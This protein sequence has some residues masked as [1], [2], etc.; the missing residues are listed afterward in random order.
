MLRSCS[1][2]KGRGEERTQGWAVVLMSR[3]IQQDHVVRVCGGRKEGRGGADLSLNV[4][5]Q[6]FNLSFLVRFL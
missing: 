6:I 3:E 4:V 1:R 5:Q 2:E